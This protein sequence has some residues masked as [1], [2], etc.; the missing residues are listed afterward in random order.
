[1]A[2]KLA[3]LHGISRTAS[4]LRVGYYDLQRRLDEQRPQVTAQRSVERRPTFVEIPATTLAPAEC[5][6]ELEHPRGRK[7]RVHLKGSATPDLAVLAHSFW[8]AEDHR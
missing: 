1:L 4:T 8:Q 5:V 2:V 6:I 3:A 7:M